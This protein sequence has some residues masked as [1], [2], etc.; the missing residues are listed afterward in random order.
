MSVK[1]VQEYLM[2]IL[3]LWSHPT[4]TIPISSTWGYGSKAKGW[5]KQN[6]NVGGFI[7]NW[8]ISEEYVQEIHGYVYLIEKKSKANYLPF[9][10]SATYHFLSHY[11]PTHS[12]FL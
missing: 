6:K 12:S 11:S 10:N 8:A 3:K 1:L 5:N 7:L 4:A 9:S 2:Q